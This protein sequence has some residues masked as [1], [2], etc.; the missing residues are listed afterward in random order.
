MGTCTHTLDTATQEYHSFF[1]QFLLTYGFCTK[2][3]TMEHS[4]NAYITIIIPGL[5]SSSYVQAKLAEVSF[6]VQYI[7]HDFCY[8]SCEAMAGTRTGFINMI[9]RTLSR[10]STTGGAICSSVVRAFAHGAIGRWVDPS[11]WTH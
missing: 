11:L 8:T 3:I 9:H 10:R 4:L 5:L 7:Y 2:R 6:C 1:S